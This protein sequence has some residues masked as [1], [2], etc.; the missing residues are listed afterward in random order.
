[1][2]DLGG[3][4]DINTVEFYN[5]DIFASKMAERGQ[6]SKRSGRR[7]GDAQTRAAI[8]AA[9]RR[10][11]GAA[12][13]EATTVR[14]VAAEAGVDPALILYFFG[15]KDGLFA[16]SVEWPFDPAQALPAVI[17]SGRAGVGGRLV[18]LMLDTWDAEAGR[19]VVVAQLRAAMGHE[20]AGRQLR[21]FLAAEILGPLTAALRCDE[22]ELRGSLVA[23][24][25]IG[26]GLA[27]H[28][29][30]LDPLATLPRDDVIAL[31]GPQVQRSLTHRLPD[32]RAGAPG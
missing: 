8:A 2:E 1:M 22:P 13:Y 25:L 7:P 26:L 29:L 6:A 23:A 16:A 3:D 21:A 11:F 28:V 24:Q 18:G 14:A 27:R 17:G 19:N 20:A 4:M 32:R 5:V 10:Q 31:V 9:A 30:A 15:S 12:G